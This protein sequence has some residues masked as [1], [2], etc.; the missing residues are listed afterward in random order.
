ML[1]ARLFAAFGAVCLL[2][3]VG[4]TAAVASTSAHAWTP[5]NHH[6]VGFGV[7]V[8]YGH[9]HHHRYVSVIKPGIWTV[10]DGLR[11]RQGLHMVNAATRP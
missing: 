7:C 11:C 4:V 1:K 9:F 8:G 5:Y 2:L 10:E 6:P 3:S